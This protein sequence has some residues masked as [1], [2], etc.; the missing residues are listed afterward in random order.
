MLSSNQEAPAPCLCSCSDW[1]LMYFSGFFWTGFGETGAFGLL[2]SCY[3]DS[4]IQKIYPNKAGILMPCVA[5]KGLCACVSG[6]VRV[7]VCVEWV[8]SPL[9]EWMV[10]FSDIFFFFFQ[11]LSS[12]SSYELPADLPEL[13]RD[14]CCKWWNAERQRKSRWESWKLG[15]G[16][17]VLYVSSLD[18]KGEFSAI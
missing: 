9:L 15:V 10:S 8:S 4:H 17:D 6:C 18:R 16:N 13:V 5:E 11:L 3:P 14:P 2:P 12:S 1:T 7:R